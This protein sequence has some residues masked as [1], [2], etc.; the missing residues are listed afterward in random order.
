MKAEFDGASRSS[1]VAALVAVVLGFAVM[2]AVPNTLQSQ[3]TGRGSA[4]ATG[5]LFPLAPIAI[6]MTVESAYDALRVAPSLAEPC[7]LDE[8]DMTVTC[9]LGISRLY[10]RGKAR[11]LPENSLAIPFDSLEL[12][13]LSE[14]RRV[15][16]YRTYHTPPT[17]A[18]FDSV[19]RRVRGFLE[20]EWGEPRDTFAGC[21]FWGRSSPQGE[22]IWTAYFC[23][24]DRD[25]LLFVSVAPRDA[26]AARAQFAPFGSFHAKP[27]NPEDLRRGERKWW[28]PIWRPL[29]IGQLEPGRDAGFL[30]AAAGVS[31]SARTC[32]RP[33]LFGDD[34]R[35][36]DCVWGRPNVRVAGYQ[37]TVLELDLVL[38]PE[39]ETARAS[40]VWLKF[41]N[42]TEPKPA[43]VEKCRTVTAALIEMWGTPIEQSE[44]PEECSVR[45]RRAPFD[46]ELSNVFDDRRTGSDVWSLWLSIGVPSNAEP[47]EWWKRW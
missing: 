36:I 27:L 1:P 47:P 34:P 45:W 23:P 40:T 12:D 21:S 38:D 46:A 29:T 17:D 9:E 32:R 41:G 8:D 3:S 39:N 19:T 18:V 20:A 15:V 16:A 4:S 43:V 44:A 5:S 31:M 14:S 22:D 35:R 6:G 42:F 26:A 37:P 28:V 11:M 7:F 13:V 24:R 10:K 25:R 30:T 2:C 33:E